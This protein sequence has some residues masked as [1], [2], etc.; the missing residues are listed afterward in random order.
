MRNI[1]QQVKAA[2][3]PMV[4]NTGCS[5]WDVEF[6][7]EAGLFYLRVYIDHPDGVSIDQCEAVSRALSDWLDEADPI[8]ESYTLEVSSAGADRTL[9]RPSDFEQFMGS[10]V[11]VR[12]YQAKDGK[13]EWVGVLT[14]YENGAVQITVD[15]TPV[16]FEKKEIAKVQLYVTF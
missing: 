5:L 10:T 3:T 2:A 13:K 12:L 4:E 11:S 9:K 16:Q 1:V 14:G 15:E 7:K 6:V 8:E